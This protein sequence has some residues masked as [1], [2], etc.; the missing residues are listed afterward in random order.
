MADTDIWGDVDA[1][2]YKIHELDITPEESERILLH[3]A[4]EWGI[5]LEMKAPHPILRRNPKLI[6][7]DYRERAEHCTEWLEKGLGVY[8]APEAKKRLMLYLPDS[9][10]YMKD[11]RAGRK[12]TTVNEKVYL[13][14]IVL[15]DEYLEVTDAQSQVEKRLG[16]K[17]SNVSRSFKRLE[18]IGLVSIAGY[19]C[20]TGKRIWRLETPHLTIHEENKE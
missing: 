8:N 12:S 6:F 1:F 5:E 18:E 15:A 10:A 4:E 19:D 7:P 3:V 9:Q 16:L 11:I 13:E 20:K 14:L 17:Q 2:V